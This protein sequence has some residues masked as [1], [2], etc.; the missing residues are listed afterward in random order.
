[1][2]LSTLHYAWSF[3]FYCGV[4]LVFITAVG[5]CKKLSQDKGKT[6]AHLSAAVAANA[7]QWRAVL[8]DPTAPPLIAAD[9]DNSGRRRRDDDSSS[10]E[11]EDEAEE[12]RRE[13]ARER[14]RERERQKAAERERERERGR[15]EKEREKRRRGGEES[16]ETDRSV[17]VRRRRRRPLSTGGGEEEADDELQQLV[18]PKGSSGSSDEQ[19]LDGYSTSPDSPSSSHSPLLFD[20]SSSASSHL[21]LSLSLASRSLHSS[22]RASALGPIVVPSAD[23]L[24]YRELVRVVHSAWREGLLRSQRTLIGTLIER[25]KE[26]GRLTDTAATVLGKVIAMYETRRR[27][28]ADKEGEGGEVDEAD[29]VAD[30]YSLLRAGEKK[31]SDDAG[32]TASI[33]SSIRAAATLA[34]TAAEQDREAAQAEEEPEVEVEAAKGELNL[35]LQH[36]LSL[37]LPAAPI[38]IEHSLDPT[39]LSFDSAD[40]P[41]VPLPPLPPQATFDPVVLANRYLSDSHTARTTLTQQLCTDKPD[42]LTSSQLASHSLPTDTSSSFLSSSQSAQASSFTASD[43][44][45]VLRPV[46]VVASLQTRYLNVELLGQMELV[47]YGVQRRMEQLVADKLKQWLRREEPPHQPPTLLPHQRSV[48]LQH[49]TDKR[50]AGE[51]PIRVSTAPM[52]AFHSPQPPSHRTA[53]TPSPSL[54][55]SS[56]SPGAPPPAVVHHY[57]AVHHTGIHPTTIHHTAPLAL[58]AAPAAAAKR[59]AS[60]ETAAPADSQPVAFPPASTPSRS[61][62]LSFAD[63]QP[64]TLAPTQAVSAKQLRKHSYTSASNRTP[65]PATPYSTTSASPTYYH[66]SPPFTPNHSH[67]HSH[68]HNTVTA[69]VASVSRP[70]SQSH[71]PFHSATSPSTVNVP[72]LPPRPPSTGSSPRTQRTRTTGGYKRENGSSATVYGTDGV[73]YASGKAVSASGS[74]GSR[75]REHERPSIKHLRSKS[76]IGFGTELPYV[77]DA[78]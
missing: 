53:T 71:S 65:T 5:A 49:S 28:P 9:D 64:A 32:D 1:M 31:E 25:E 35:K 60:S 62:A 27:R 77:R 33:V 78:V 56:L 76:L 17:G 4:T 61:R 2:W 52:S 50:D 38:H 7:P 10:Y 16:D 70:S 12:E 69:P 75:G 21:P 45:P 58:P 13:R 42:L 57:T 26:R 19:L 29:V 3:L 6:Y 68:N 40:V 23:V 51:T 72:V 41:V 18:Q 47:M 74:S 73:V 43:G 54:S 36:L 8:A 48:P 22:S 59:S 30:V 63:R 66:T 20:S 46:Y 44:V 37:P 14:D 11:T 24:A 15:E 55:S 39:Q 34:V 67:S